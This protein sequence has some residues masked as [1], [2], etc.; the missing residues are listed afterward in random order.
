ME[1]L[2]IYW[3]NAITN[4]QNPN[5]ELVL[6]SGKLPSILDLRNNSFGAEYYFQRL[7]YRWNPL[8]GFELRA[9]AA[10]G[11]KYIKPNNNILSLE[12]PLRP[13]FDFGTLYDS[14]SLRSFQY[15]GQFSYAHFFQLWKQLTLMGRYKT[16]AVFNSRNLLYTNEL[17]RIGGQ[18][19]M[20][21][22]DE[23]SIFASWYQVATA[24]LRYLLGT[25]SYTYLFG[26]FSYTENSSEALNPQIW[27]YGF[28]VGVA[29][30]T[31]V[32]I[33]GLSYAL[34]SS[35]DSPLLFRNGKIHFGYVNIF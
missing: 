33:F 26:D 21:G 19:V 35:F 17:L 18:Q 4:V 1:I 25:N 11:V 32:G 6:L 8:K 7:D 22:F 34:G 3:K 23:Q 20:R 2:K 10:V 12:D 31:K 24:E 5:T 28:G 15:S 9:A 30:E 29:L 27:R 14:I 16:A 13:D